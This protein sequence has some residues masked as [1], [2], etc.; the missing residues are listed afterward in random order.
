M[1][2]DPGIKG[3]LLAVSSKGKIAA[4]QM[5]VVSRVG[6]KKTKAGNKRIYHDYDEDE[7]VALLTRWTEDQ[8]FGHPERVVVVVEMASSR[9]DEASMSA[10]KTG[11][12]YGL[13]AGIV[14]GMGFD[15]LTPYPITWR[16]A[17]IPKIKKGSKT[18]HAQEAERIYPAITPFLRG[19]RGGL[20]DGIGDAALLARYGWLMR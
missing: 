3:A 4:R 1:G 6:T 2:I 9:P 20:R 12:L 17:V 13:V 14:K 19:P 7:I 8:A 15:R 10:L 18:I 16:R 11:V 5:P